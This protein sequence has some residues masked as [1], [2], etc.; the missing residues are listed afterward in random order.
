MPGALL[1]VGA[2]VS[3][4]HTGRATPVT[5][6]PRVLVSGQATVLMNSSYTVTGCTLPSPP[7]ANGPCVSAQWVT[8]ATR[9]TSNGK[10]LLLVDSQATCAPTG[11]PLI[12]T[13]TQMRAIGT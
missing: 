5:L 12:I 13:L 7:N 8:G 6:N 9:I 2:T 3:C 1:D 10:P 4:S 11:T